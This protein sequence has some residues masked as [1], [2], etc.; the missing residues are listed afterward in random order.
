MTALRT[1]K[2]AAIALLGMA[3]SLLTVL[4]LSAPAS[5]AQAKPHRSHAAK[6]EFQES[7]PCPA[8]GRTAGRTAGKCRGYVIDHIRP[9]ACGGADAPHNMQWQTKAEARAKDRHERRR[10]RRWAF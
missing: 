7:H 1:A 10:C 2:T 5:S 3:L 6:I 9:L 4:A 8:T